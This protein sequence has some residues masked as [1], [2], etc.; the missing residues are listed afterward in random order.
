[1]IIYS[2]AHPHFRSSSRTTSRHI[3]KKLLWIASSSMR[4]RALPVLLCLHSNH[5]TDLSLAL[6]HRDRLSVPHSNW[7]CPM[8]SKE[9][10]L[11][12]SLIEWQTIKANW[13]ICR[14]WRREWPCSRAGKAHFN[15]EQP[16]LLLA[17]TLLLL[18]RQ[19]WTHHSVRW[20]RVYL[21]N[22][23]IKRAKSGKLE[24]VEPSLQLLRWA[25]LWLQD[26]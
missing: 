16:L 1:M 15:K 21:K 8:A 6:A 13:K 7:V 12:S 11:D 19:I 9:W 10:R 3:D 22:G 20:T 5:K 14:K 23:W 4:Q 26:L 25:P 24:K 17:I 2:T 18:N